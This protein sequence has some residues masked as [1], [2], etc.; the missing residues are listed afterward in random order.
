MA[1]SRRSPPPDGG[2]AS[3]GAFAPCDA[4]R[5]VDPHSEAAFAL[6]QAV[7]AA[8]DVHA[9]GATR[10]GV[11][12]SG[13]RD[14]MA[15]FDVAAQVCDERSIAL[16][17]LHVH[18]GLSAHADAWAGHCANVCAQLNVPFA[19]RNVTIERRPRQS[20]EAAARSARYDALAALAHESGCDAVL[21]AHHADDQAETVL[22]QL[23]RGAGP[24][25]LAAMP[26]AQ[27]RDDVLFLRPWLDVPRATIERYVD[28]RGIDYVDDDSNASTR[29]ARNALRRDVAPALRAIAPGYP[30]T[31]VRAARLQADTSALL[32]ELAAADAASAFDGRTLSRD[33]LRALSPSRARN[34]M[35]WFIG[36]RGLKAPSGRRLGAMVAQLVSARDDACVRIAHDGAEVGLHLGR[37]AVHPPSSDAYAV[38]WSGEDT[39]ALPHGTLVFE[40]VI[41]T[42]L[43]RARVRAA[44]VIV[45]SRCGGERI[46]LDRARPRRALSAILQERGV[47][48][49]E[50]ESLPL[51]FC[52][53]TLAAV[54]G[55]GIAAAFRASAGEEGLVLVWRRAAC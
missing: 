15:L 33:A 54:P 21:L 4:D 35:R 28:V 5:R 34:L 3:T 9:S 11:A 27:K 25:G 10:V 6:S 36:Q 14:S 31:L 45:R 42:G 41:G 52:D 2:G 37:I 18:H 39:L 38:A 44:R 13:G 53:E 7:A 23:L 50:R 47:P 19:A 46:E 22:L 43:S 29:F 1:G 40:P 32:D 26:V 17:A 8:L 16:A 49:W 30:R 55:V 12:L 51:V 24:A 48:P 20:L